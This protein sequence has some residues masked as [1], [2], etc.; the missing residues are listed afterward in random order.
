[1][2]RISFLSLI[3]LFAS[4]CSNYSPEKVYSSEELKELTGTMA[5]FLYKKPDHVA[6]E[7]RTKPENQ[8]HYSE[9]QNACKGKFTHIKKQGDTLYFNFMYTDI[10]SLYEH[11]K[12][13]G[14][15]VFIV[16][17]EVRYINLYYHTPRL[18]PK[19]TSKVN[20][21]L[22]G[23]L[24]KNGHV[25]K[26]V[27]NRDLIHTPNDDFYYDTE[28]KHWDYTPNSS[29]NFLKEVKEVEM[30]DTASVQK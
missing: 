15:K 10:S 5:P 13:F 4:A 26:Y 20:D 1:M 14:G 3:L 27:G 23:E 9:M 12:S 29:W 17:E 24:A 28:N 22:F 18:E 2:K 8:R 30:P 16:S 11:Y 21:L 25:N 19:D 7:D 6:F